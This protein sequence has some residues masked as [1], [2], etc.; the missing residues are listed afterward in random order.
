[1]DWI[2][3]IDDLDAKIQAHP[4][5]KDWVK[6]L[7]DGTDYKSEWIIWSIDPVNIRYSD[8][9]CEVGFSICSRWAQV[10][11]IVRFTTRRQIAW[12]GRGI[13]DAELTAVLQKATELCDYLWNN[14][15]F[16]DENAYPNV[17]I[18]IDV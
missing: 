18:T 8:K 11:V 5:S 15:M 10:H 7:A 2:K 6:P 3:Q 4:L 16:T 12:E 9:S 13:G 14:H 17:Q 1:M